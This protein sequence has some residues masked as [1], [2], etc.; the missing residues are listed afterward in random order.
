[1]IPSN[2]E[3]YASELLENLEDKFPQC[4]TV[5]SR[6]NLQLHTDVKGLTLY[7]IDTII[8]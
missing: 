1:M 3:A 5:I 7:E 6:F 8:N 2:S 4:N